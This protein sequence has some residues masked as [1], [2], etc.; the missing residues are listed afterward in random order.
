MLKCVGCG[1]FLFPPILQC[2]S[3]HMECRNCF[4]MKA[5]CPKCRQ[6]MVE[7]PAKFAETITE[8]FKVQCSYSGKGCQETVP[9]K[10]SG[11]GIKPFYKELQK[12]KI[13]YQEQLKCIFEVLWKYKFKSFRTN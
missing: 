10:V 4:D 1:R 5:D 8:Q 2:I 6:K 7:I 11:A 3:G 13:F 12:V 9:F